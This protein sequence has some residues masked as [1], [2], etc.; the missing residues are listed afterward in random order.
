MSGQSQRE[1]LTSRLAIHPNQEL[2]LNS[3]SKR[4]SEYFDPCQA[5]A[6]RSIK[7]IHR[8]AEDRD[9]CLDYFQ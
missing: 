4:T 2:D 7:C 1:L 8:N 5:L 9:L 6:S 3:H